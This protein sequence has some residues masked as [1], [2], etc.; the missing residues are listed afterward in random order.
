MN[1]VR[2]RPFEPGNKLGRGRPKGSRNKSS[3]SPGQDLLD[4]YA[5]HLI[6]KTISLGLAG[7][8]HALRLC[9]ERISPARRDAVIRMNLPAIRKA[10]D[11]DKAA[12]KV[13]QG[14]RRG[15][16][17]PVEAGRVMS[18][19]EGRLKIFETVELAGRIEKVEEKMAAADSLPRA[20]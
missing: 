19:L 18:I 9:F 4:E 11:L 12:E 5:P 20:A 15:N 17:T 3:K 6:R 8:T 2:G 16:I 1:R 7:D 10:E 14:M 13:T